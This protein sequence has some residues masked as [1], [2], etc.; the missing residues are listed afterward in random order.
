[1]NVTEA[2]AWLSEQVDRM[3]FSAPVSHV[4]NPLA[5][6]F[7]NHSTYTQ[8]YGTPQKQVILVGMNPGPFGMAQTGIPFGDVHTVGQ[9]F[10]LKGR[11]GRPAREHEK[12]P[13][14]GLACKRVEVSGKR[15][16]GAMRDRFGSPE[17]FFERFFVA[18]YCPLCFIE[19]SGR[20]RTPDKLPVHERQPLFDACDTHLKMIVDCLQPTYVIGI[21]AFA[22]QRVRAALADYSV[23]TGRV[24][25]PSPANPAA[26]RNWA[27]AFWSQLDSIM[28]D[29]DE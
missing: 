4:Y 1:M 29:R 8:R 25:H 14:V 10:G 27:E 3:S 26:N 23:V 12:R 15:L 19:A 21:G 7:E 20:N 18:N 17:V 16:W 13:V 5:Y 24:L 11:V 28:T 9:W 22:E 2:A 6:A